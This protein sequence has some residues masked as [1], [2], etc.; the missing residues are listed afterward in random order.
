MLDASPMH[1]ST[2][3]TYEKAAV[4]QEE[5][6]EFSNFDLIDGPRNSWKNM[7]RECGNPPPFP[8]FPKRA[9]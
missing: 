4:F 1:Q 7:L 9:C 6:V 3:R 5:G 2:Q 8:G